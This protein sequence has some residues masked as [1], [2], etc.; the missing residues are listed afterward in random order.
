MSNIKK[1]NFE[2]KKKE[3]RTYSKMFQNF[4]DGLGQL[5]EICQVAYDIIEDADIS[6]EEASSRMFN[7]I[8]DNFPSID[9]RNSSFWSINL[10]STRCYIKTNLK[11]SFGWKFK[12]HYD[13][14]S[15]YNV[16]ENIEMTITD[17]DESETIRAM[18][19]EY[20]WQIKE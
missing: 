14:V 8:A 19:E 3:V 7:A 6:P 9:D 11:V 16:I 5:M 12:Y 2:K 13:V 20:D 1:K 17:F 10:S 15:K 18:A 4:N